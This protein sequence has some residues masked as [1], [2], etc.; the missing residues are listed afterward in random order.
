MTQQ[1]I[2]IFILLFTFISQGKLDCQTV[3][4][5]ESAQCVDLT[6][7]MK[8]FRFPSQSILF[9][10]ISDAKNDSLW[11]KTQYK[12]LNLSP[13]SLVEWYK[14]TIQNTSRESW[15]LDVDNPLIDTIEVYTITSEMVSHQ[16]TGDKTTHENKTGFKTGSW[17]I[18]VISN[19][20]PE[21]EIYIKIIA[22][23]LTR[24]PVTVRTLADKAHAESQRNLLYGFFFGWMCIMLIYNFFVWYTTSEKA[25][26]YY[27]LYNAGISLLIATLEGYSRNYFWPGSL[28]LQELAPSI[29]SALAG[30]GSLLFVRYFLATE[31]N[32]PTINSIIT[33][34][35]LWD[36]AAIV[37]CISGFV[38]I[39]NFMVQIGALTGSMLIIAASIIVLRTG[40]RP[41][42]YFT[43]GYLIAMIGIIVYIMGNFGILPNTGIV[44]SSI[45]I[46]S[47]IEIAMLSLAIADRLKFSKQKEEKARLLEAK[48]KEAARKELEHTILAR[49]EKMLRQNQLLAIQRKALQAKS[50]EIS[51][52][53]K[54]SDDLLLNILPFDVA[55]ELKNNGRTG[56]KSLRDVSVLFTDIENFTSLSEKMSPDDLVSEL[57]HYFSAF[58]RIVFKYGMEK[59]KTIGDAYLAVAGIGNNDEKHAQ[60]AILAAQEM[61]EFCEKSIQEG[62]AFRIRAGIHSGPAVAGVVGERKFAF[63]IWGDTVNTAA[64]MEQGGIPGFVNVSE[65]TWKRTKDDF[66]FQYRGKMKAK[67][68]GELD[69]YF[70]LK[71]LNQGLIIPDMT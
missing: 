7:N 60:H 70:A 28:L 22:K 35:M 30:I 33:F 69:M 27:C 25:Y 31:R 64:R 16:I 46:T 49:T 12:R 44:I 53:K 36:L 19:A 52:A 63:D 48:A 21:T 68:K 14:V 47:S 57:H 24:L 59:I 32:T 4:L 43:Q 56:V 58:D 45:P 2:R 65:E 17:M 55:E 62:H 9:T 39:A 66:E 15:Y 20:G 8:R 54:K 67:N 23:D 40:Y 41:A 34:N 38:R 42:I 6:G 13:V 5:T 26:L 37:I 51:E 1:I 10:D 71:V 18:P 3:V 29:F 61:I 11:E 50:E